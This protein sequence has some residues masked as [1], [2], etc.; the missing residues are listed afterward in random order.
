MDGLEGPAVRMTHVLESAVGRAAPLED[1]HLTPR[2]A[3]DRHELQPAEQSSA[4]HLQD[5]RRVRNTPE[6]RETMHI[7]SFTHE[8]IDHMGLFTQGAIIRGVKNPVF[9]FFPR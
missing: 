8:T 4:G 6:L 2:G 1:W 7:K 5:T 3:A 9:V